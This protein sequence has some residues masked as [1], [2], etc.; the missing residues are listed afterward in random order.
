MLLML[1]PVE[2]IALLMAVLCEKRRWKVMEGIISD[3]LC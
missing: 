3:S 1:V 2:R